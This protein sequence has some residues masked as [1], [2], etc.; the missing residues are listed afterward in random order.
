MKKLNILLILLLSIIFSCKKD[1]TTNFGGV[2]KDVTTDAPIVNAHVFA[3]ERTATGS[4]YGYKTLGHTYTDACGNFEFDFGKNSDDIYLKAEATGYFDNENN[5]TLI[6]GKKYPNDLVVHLT[7]RS[8]L[9]LNLMKVDTT[10]TSIEVTILTPIN[11][12]INAY[13]ENSAP[14]MSK[15][16][17][18]NGN[19]DIPLRF[20][21]K[22][23]KLFTLISTQDITQNYYCF[24]NDTT[25]YNINY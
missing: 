5:E 20:I 8:H 12:T 23:Y 18:C 19:Q 21:I 14:T 4:G 22:K 9:K 17:L 1:K 3:T 7:P 13:I 2:V 16:I 15:I 25:E 11:V 24:A 10:V 6:S